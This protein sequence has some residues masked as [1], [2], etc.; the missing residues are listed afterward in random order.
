MITF[1]SKNQIIISLNFA[2]FFLYRYFQKY[3]VLS[4]LKA[5][6]HIVIL[7]QLLAEASPLFFG[8]YMRESERG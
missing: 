5:Y 7:S 1:F 8:F 3:F 2:P 6:R 4:N